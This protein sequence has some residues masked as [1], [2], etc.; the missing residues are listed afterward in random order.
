MTGQRA[1]LAASGRELGGGAG[2]A[3]ARR[4]RSRHGAHGCPSRE[5]PGS[6]VAWWQHFQG[7]NGIM[8][9]ITALSGG[10]QSWAM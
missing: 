4:P 1:P 9:V 8:W 10:H 6:L 2:T 7:V 5:A 3:L